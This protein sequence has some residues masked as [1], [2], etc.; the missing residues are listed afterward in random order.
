[1]VDQ[2][3]LLKRF[4]RYM[5]AFEK[6]CTPLSVEIGINWRTLIR[7]YRGIPIYD[8]CAL[9]IEKFLYERGF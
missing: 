9:R 3:E 4:T 2:A 6:S 7:F 1:M 5:K 8:R